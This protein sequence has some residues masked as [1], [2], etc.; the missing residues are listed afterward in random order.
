ML[1]KTDS[2][3]GVKDVALKRKVISEELIADKWNTI[4]MSLFVIGVG[5]APKLVKF[6]A[7]RLVFESKAD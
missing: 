4:W 7:Q 6:I 1:C 3:L 2:C 5:Y